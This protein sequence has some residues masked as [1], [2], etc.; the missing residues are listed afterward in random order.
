M[1]NK[2][3]GVQLS[4]AVTAGNT[5]GTAAWQ[6]APTETAIAPGVLRIAGAVV[7]ATV[8]EIS[9]AALFPEASVTV[10]IIVCWPRPSSVPG[11]GLW[12]MTNKLAGGQ[13]SA[14][15]TEDNTLGTAAWQ[16]AATGTVSREGALRIVG[17]VVSATANESV[18][19]VRLPEASVT[20][21]MIGC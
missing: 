2:L 12:L 4:A 17:G 9:V 10:A 11:A 1:T 8:N 6:L 20:V 15:V 14:A 5:L 21:T 3:A 13:L 18:P 7:S 19:A 16:S